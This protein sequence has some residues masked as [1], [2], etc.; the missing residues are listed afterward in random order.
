MIYFWFTHNRL[1]FLDKCMTKMEYYSSCNINISDD[2]LKI[3]DLTD[4]GRFAHGQKDTAKVSVAMV[5]YCRL[6][7]YTVYF[8]ILWKQSYFLRNE[9]HF[10]ESCLWKKIKNRHE[11]LKW[12]LKYYNI[13]LK[14]PLDNVCLSY[15]HIQT[16][17]HTLKIWHLFGWFYFTLNSSL[18]PFLEIE[19]VLLI[20]N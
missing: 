1:Y 4:L 5:F 11:Q 9:K 17:I 12:F 7:W 15:T 13:V 10:E 16:H 19:I 14:D 6:S 2:N 20:P 3:L 18:C 8:I